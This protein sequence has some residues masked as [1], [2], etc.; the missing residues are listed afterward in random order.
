MTNDELLL[1]LCFLV[2]VVEKL[3]QLNI[4][5]QGKDNLIIDSFNHINTFQ[6]KL[7]LFEFQLKNNNVQ[8][9]PLLNELK[10]PKHIVIPIH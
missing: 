9:F 6:K 10:N 2:D 8:H 3:N 4:S 7:L 5:L 1:D